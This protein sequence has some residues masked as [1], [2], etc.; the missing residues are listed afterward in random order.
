MSLIIKEINNK[1]VWESFLLN[2][3]EKTFLDSWNWGE[4]QKKERNKIWRLGIYN[5]EELMGLAL[6]LK[7]KAKRG[8]FLF[9]PH[10]PNIISNFPGRLKEDSPEGCF[11][12]SKQKV[13]RVLLEKLKEIAKEERAIFLR[14]A[15]IWKRTE[16]NIKLFKDLGFKEAPLHI[17]P[18]N[19]WELDITPLEDNLLMDMRKTTRYLIRK[20]GKNQDVEVV[21]TQNIEDL[22]TFDKIYQETASRQGFVPFSLDFLKK[23]FSIFSK[24]NQIT[25]FLGKYKGKVISAAVIIFWQNIAFYHHGA[26]LSEYKKIPISYL[27]Q[28]EAIKEAKKRGCKKYNFWGIAPDVKEKEDLKKSKHPWAGLTLFK[29][30]FS[31]HRKEYVKT[32]DFPL[33]IKYIFT[34]LFEK[35]R[36]IKRGY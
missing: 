2:C 15:P 4:F 5:K 24:D 35:L 16:E 30:G 13:L 27:L 3:S 8:T 7:I 9:V 14:I 20:A 34:Y 1:E 18:E 33:S 28:W 21:Q 11:P 17:H 29:M 25:I 23:Q 32:Q 10:G 26:S 12:I 6:I 31:G 22:E 36:K 19:S